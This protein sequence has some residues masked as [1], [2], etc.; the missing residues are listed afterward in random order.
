MSE[1]QEDQTVEEVKPKR[2]DFRHMQVKLTKEEFK[3]VELWLVHNDI[4]EKNEFLK[5]L[6]LRKVRGYE[7]VQ[8][9]DRLYPS[10]QSD[11]Y[12]TFR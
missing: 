8:T 3:E 1:H 4:S 9:D 6:I 11:G 5:Q 2:G 7:P 10:T 12:D